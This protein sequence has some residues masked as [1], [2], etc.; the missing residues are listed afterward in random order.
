[1]LHALALNCTLNPSPMESS[2]DVLLREIIS[3]FALHGVGTEQIRMVDYD[4]RPGVIRNRGSG[5]D[6]PELRTRILAAD[7]LIL[8][9]PIRIENVSSVCQSVL[10]RMDAFLPE[11]GEQDR[12]TAY[13]RVATMGAIDGEGGGTHH[14]IGQMSHVLNDMGFTLPANASVSWAGAAG[15]KPG[16]GTSSVLPDHVLDSTDKMAR[17]AVHMIRLL[18]DSEYPGE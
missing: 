6:W 4:I 12:K 13:G 9:T 15:G 3:A 16:A 1:M 10:E 7:I 8:V 17:N 5:D 18:N 11:E 14:A 2:C